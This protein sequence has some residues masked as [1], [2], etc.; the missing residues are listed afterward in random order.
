MSFFD[1]SKYHRNDHEIRK[2][3]DEK[4]RLEQELEDQ[5]WQERSANYEREQEHYREQDRRERQRYNDMEYRMNL[6]NH[7]R[8]I[9]EEMEDLKLRHK[10]GIEQ[11]GE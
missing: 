5:K 7:V 10:F 2:L 6:Q 4:T 3:H 11:E 9:I 8:V 1:I